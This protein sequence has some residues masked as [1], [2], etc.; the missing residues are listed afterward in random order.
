MEKLK[1]GPNGGLL[2]C[3]EFLEQNIELVLQKLRKFQEDQ[4]YFIFDCPGQV[5]LYTHHDSM[6]NIIEILTKMNFRL[7]AINLVDSFYCND[8]SKFISVLLTSLS[9]ML[10]LALPHINVLSKMDLLEKYGKLPFNIEYYTDVLD[11][12]Y[13]VDGLKDDPFAKKYAS[14]NEALVGVIQD[15]SLVSFNTLRVDNKES[16]L[17]LM[18]VIDK[19]NGY[20]YGGLSTEGE[21]VMQMMSKA[22]GADLRFNQP[23]DRGVS[24]QDVLT[25]MM[26]PKDR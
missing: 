15:Y 13:L 18:K 1:L 24:M 5:E 17:E 16:M 11:L 14:L 12:N 3:M 21:D 7:A 4:F 22:V 25:E 6:K 26:E 2:Y 20:F 9:T 10:Q 23:T 8:A 19:A